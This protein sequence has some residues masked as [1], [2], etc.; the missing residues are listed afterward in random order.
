MG[1]K[2]ELARGAAWCVC[3]AATAACSPATADIEVG[4]QTAAMGVKA[5]EIIDL[6]V[7][8]EGPSA[9][10]AVGAA[11]SSG[12]P[13]AIARTRKRLAELDTLRDAVRPHLLGNGA[14]IIAELRRLANAFHIRAP[15]SAIPKILAI[16]HVIGVEP[17][18]LFHRSLHSSLP[19][20]GAPK[21]WASNAPVHGEGITLGIMD[22]GIDYMHA[23]FGGNG[24][25]DKFDKDDS[26]LIE[27]GSFPTTRVVGGH[28]FAGNPYNPNE[29]ESTPQPD[30]DPIDCGG[31]GS[32]VAGIA[33]G[34]GVLSDGTP[35][36]G[37]YDMSFDISQFRVAPGVAPLADLYSL[38]VFGCDGSTRL[39]AEALEWAADPNDDGD[40]S[41]RLDVVN[42]SLGSPYGNPNPTN[43]VMLQHYHTVQCG[44][45]GRQHL[46]RDARRRAGWCR[47]RLCVRRSVVHRVAP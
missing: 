22:T 13:E 27:D 30:D 4:A 46:H 29:G 31:H 45:H 7:V 11:A 44:R 42:A 39:V 23:D 28:D 36:T 40:F 34:S 6:Y 33:A 18:P 16:S 25:P 47:R 32:H 19:V 3:I 10:G 8:L 17:V 38:K 5:N 2:V 37:T 12:T 41:D 9:V 14:T 24:N 15:H 43:A 20:V 1:R 35:Y 21:A 26:T